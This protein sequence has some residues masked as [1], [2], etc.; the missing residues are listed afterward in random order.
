[1][2]ILWLTQIN[3]TRRTFRLY[4]SA[5]D[6]ASISLEALRREALKPYAFEQIIAS[7]DLGSMCFRQLKLPQEGYVFGDEDHEFIAVELVPGG[8]WLITLSS[9]TPESDAWLMAWDLEGVGSDEEKPS[10]PVARYKIECD[11]GV[12]TE[13][14]DRRLSTQPRPLHQGEGIVC[15]V[16]TSYQ[17]VDPR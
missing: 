10:V 1:M 15:F 12:P 5:V 7:K 13:D 4:S 16:I 9:A 3:N 11:K 6:V 2:K 17:E 14:V 8:K